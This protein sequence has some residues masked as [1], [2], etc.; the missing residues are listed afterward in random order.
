MTEKVTIL[1]EENLPVPLLLL[2]AP[3]D[4]AEW[5]VNGLQWSLEHG[6]RALRMGCFDTGPAFGFPVSSAA[7]VVLRHVTDFLY[8]HPE[9]ESLTI[10]CGDDPSWKA[11]RFCWNLWYAE[12][13]PKHEG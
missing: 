12:F 11:Y 5:Y 2:A 8:A 13:K 9:V 7:E 1:R 10:L 6:E 4:L 3:E